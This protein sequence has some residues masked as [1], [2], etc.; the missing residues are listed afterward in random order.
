MD[1]TA[2]VGAVDCTRSCTRALA[3]VQDVVVTWERGPTPRRTDLRRFG[4]VWPAATSRTCSGCSSFR[5]RC[6]LTRTHA[7]ARPPHPVNTHTHTHTRALTHALTHTHIRTHTHTQY[8]THTHTHTHT[9]Q[10][11]H[12]H[13]RTGAR[14]HTPRR[15]A[16]SLGCLRSGTSSGRSLTAFTSA[17]ASTS[18]HGIPH[19]TVSRAARYPT[20][21]GIPHGTV[22]RAARYPA[23]HGIPRGTVSRAARYPFAA[24]L[25][26]AQGMPRPAMY[27]NISFLLVNAF[28]N[29]FAPL[30]GGPL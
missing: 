23:R 8:H 30:A 2:V 21:H 7:D 14:C 24:C 3:G 1:A 15:Y 4:T 22:S 20:R 28:L 19:G 16:S 13:A 6:A 26:Q 27:N 12:T 5:R 18:R 17:C 11:T 29:W 9:T 10:H 25:P